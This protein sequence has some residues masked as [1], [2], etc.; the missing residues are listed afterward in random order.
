[1]TDTRSEPSGTFQLFNPNNPSRFYIRNLPHWRQRGATYFVTLRQD[2]SIPAKV[3]AECLD[4]R[5]RWCRA[6]KLDLNIKESDSDRFNLI[7]S[8]IPEGVRRAFERQQA[9]MLHEELD[10]CHGSCVL[11]HGPPRKIVLDSLAHFHGERLCLGDAVVM[12]NHVHA[13]VTPIGD[14]ELEDILGSIKKWSSRLIGEWL[15]EQSPE[16]HPGGP[17]HNKPRF[18]QQESYDRI[19]RDLEELTMFRNYIANN[20]G[21]A[22]IHEGSYQYI[23]APWLDAFAQRTHL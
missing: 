15:G 5:Q 6:H 2:D 4:I 22:K 3:L 11:R 13:L 23:A 18:W 16:L 19:V 8:Q 10:R 7:Y 14:F 9:R 12:P 21:A 17:D 20:P 1:M